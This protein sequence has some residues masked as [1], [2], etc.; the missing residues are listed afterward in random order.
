MPEEL[1][2]LDSVLHYVTATAPRK[3]TFWNMANVSGGQIV[4]G[5]SERIYLTFGPEYASVTAGFRYMTSALN[6]QIVNLFNAGLPFPFVTSECSLNHVGD[7]RLRVKW[8][9]GNDGDNFATSTATLTTN[10]EYYLMF[11]ATIISRNQVTVTVSLNTAANVII[12]PV[13]IGT[14]IAGTTFKTASVGWNSP[15][16]SPG[17]SIKDI[18]ITQTEMLGDVSLACL[19][20]NAP[21]DV[22]QLTPNPAVA[23]WINVSQHNPPDLT[24]YNAATAALQK[25][26]YNLDDLGSTSLAILGVQQVY[27]P[28]KSNA[29]PGSFK[30]TL[31]TAG[32]EFQG[33][34]VFPS[35]DNFAPFVCVPNR[36][37]PNTGADFT[38]AL[39][40]A[41]QIGPQ[42]IT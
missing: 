38:A 17:A 29:G 35:A 1:L 31:K 22:T 40:N 21:G 12:G 28:Q 41:I 37:N 27:C 4:I 23:N 30:P 32:V 16:G 10:T 3:Y 6:G 24:A 39:I 18:V 11:T 8:N 26:L 2:R 34:E 7:G 19:F 36:K 5:G 9:N 25:D 20:P 42:R 13:T 14:V 15:G 33:D